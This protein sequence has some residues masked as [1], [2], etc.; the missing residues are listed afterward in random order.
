MLGY[1]RCFVCGQDNPVGLQTPFRQEGDAVIAT[2]RC[3][4]R[5]AGWPGVQH[6]G[7][8]AAL[9][10]EAAGYVPQ[11]L[12]LVAM[13]AK[14]DVEFIEPI[15]VGEMIRVEGRAVSQNRRIVEVESVMVG[16][17]GRVKAKSLAKMAILNEQQRLKLGL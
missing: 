3:E 10:D 12:G 9:L 11:F 13:T 16:E 1:T 17:D 5:H 4:E 2:F 6:G 7:I 15:R 14:L 8:T